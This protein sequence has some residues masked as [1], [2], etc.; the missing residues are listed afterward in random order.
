[1]ATASTTMPTTALTMKLLIDSSPQRQRVVFAEAGKDTIDF[2]FS[3][4]AIPAGTAVK[5]LGK[6]Q[7]MVGCMEN[8]YSSAE[9]LDDPYVQPNVAKD[10]ILCTTMAFP[11]AARPN[12]FLFRLP[13]PVSAPKKFYN[14]TTGWYECRRK[15][16]DVY[17]TPCP[18]CRSGMVTEANLLSPVAQGEAKKG[19]VQGGMVTYMVTDDLVISPMSNVSTIALLN[20]CAVRDLGTLQDRT[21]QIGYKEGLEILKA[22]VQSK[23]VLTD[24]FIGKKPPSLGNGG[25][26]ATLSNGRRRESLTWRA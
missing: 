9:K 14:C 24:V 8:L 5:L 21:V 10:A 12:S 19:F 15:V 11:A 16:T 18:N 4:L 6:D 25:A 20:A 22:S 7:S 2:L 3:L 17:G 13:E 23:T 26:S 1:M